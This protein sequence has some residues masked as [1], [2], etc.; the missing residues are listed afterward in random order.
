MN[1]Q[2]CHAWMLVAAALLS[3]GVTACGSIGPTTV[4]R[5]RFDYVTAISES[6]K[7]Q[8]LLNIVKLRYAD[9]PVFMDIGQVISGYELE[10]TVSA[11][12]T[13]GDK[14]WRTAGGAL[15]TFVNVGASGRYLDRPTVTYAPLTGAD[16]VKTMMTPFPP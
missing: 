14:D 16:F 5:D 2:R 15:G 13:L 4:D 1:M 8:M 7:K 11:G 3:L 12:G 9:V 6:W 10:G